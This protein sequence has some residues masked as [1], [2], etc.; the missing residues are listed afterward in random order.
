MN[1]PRRAS[2]QRLPGPL[3]PPHVT[4][5]F[6]GDGN[7]YAPGERLLARYRVDSVDET[8]VTAVERSVVWYSEG[9]GEEDLGIVFFDRLAA[10]RRVSEEQSSWQ[11][12]TGAISMELPR[13]PLSY[14]GLIVKIRWCVRLRLFFTSG[15]DFVSEHI[16]FLGDIP[17]A[18]P[19]ELV[20]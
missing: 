9:K 11:P 3:L 12:L 8:L 5:S 19:P 6:R 2:A 13:S 20:A 15:R 10:G 7:I 17:V 16:F 18:R 14:E 4:V 1:L